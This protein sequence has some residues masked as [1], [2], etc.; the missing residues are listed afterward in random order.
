MTSGVR[1]KRVP[2]PSIRSIL[3]FGKLTSSGHRRLMLEAMY[4]L[5]EERDFTVRRGDSSF[6]VVASGQPAADVLAETDYDLFIVRRVFPHPSRALA[7]FVASSDSPI[8]VLEESGVLVEDD[9]RGH[10]NGQVILGRRSG[11]VPWAGPIDVAREC[12][13]GTS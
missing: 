6:R 7:E 3:R 13:R 1:T 4:A 10:A 11:H 8:L 12:E 9:V 2:S 5:P